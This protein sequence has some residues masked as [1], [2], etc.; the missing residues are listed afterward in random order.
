M[1]CPTCAHKMERVSDHRH[2]CPRCGTLATA[3]VP[4]LIALLRRFRNDLEGHA[5]LIARWNALGIGDAIDRP[6]DR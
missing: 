1:E 4:S 3:T 5:D 6:E 2:A